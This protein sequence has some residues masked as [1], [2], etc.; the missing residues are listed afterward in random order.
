MIGLDFVLG[1]NKTLKKEI[2]RNTNSDQ[3]AVETSACRFM[4]NINIG[5]DLLS[6]GNAGW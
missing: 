4:I 1:V 5:E 6:S 3:A 2:E